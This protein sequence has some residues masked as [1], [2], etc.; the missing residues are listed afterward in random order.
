MLGLYKYIS[1]VEVAVWAVA[2]RLSGASGEDGEVGSGYG[3]GFGY[4]SGYGFG[5]GFGSGF[6]KDTKQDLV[7]VTC[8]A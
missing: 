5:F 3:F 1:T 8:E 6:V 7:T 4:G 2:D